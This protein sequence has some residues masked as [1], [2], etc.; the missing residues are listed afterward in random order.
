MICITDMTG[1]EP[2]AI[3]IPVR[4]EAEQLPALLHALAAQVGAP[5]FTLCLH[6]DN[7][8]DDSAGVVAAMAPTMPF[9]IRT[10]Q[11]HGG[12]F[13]NAGQARREAMALAA[14]GAPG[15]VVMTTDADGQPAPDWIAANLAG[16]READL[17]AGRIVRGTGPAS[18]ARDRVETYLDQLHATRRLIDPV[19]WEGAPS[20]H[21]TSGASLAL[22]A[23]DYLA[24]GGFAPVPHGEDAALGDT[25]AR[26]GWRVRR[27][28]AVVVR[29]SA[30]R[31]GRASHG[32]AAT[33]AALD[34]GH[35]PMVHH[36]DDE[37]WRY[38]HH[39]AARRLHGSGR[40]RDLAAALG[41]AEREV[42]LVADDCANGEAFAARIVG[43]P[44]GGMRLVTLPH[45]ELLLAAATPAL[46]DVA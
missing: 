19:P 17:V 38:R 2:I 14:A 20:H 44:P 41:L 29:T 43:A 15:G 22:R 27:D 33:L 37:Q 36:P 28:A 7:C 24:L 46:E 16:L 5:A 10:G 18:A 13:P 8:A 4:D 21:W 6:F 32:F 12:L 42:A 31:H 45:A 39:A 23:A 26:A 30:R 34:A 3:A 9:P 35:V 1:S 25:A 11:R 40:Y